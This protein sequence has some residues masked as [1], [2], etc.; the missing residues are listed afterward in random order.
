MILFA[1]SFVGPF[2]AVLA[3]EVDSSNAHATLEVDLA[4]LW[5]ERGG[6]GADPTRVGYRRNALVQLAKHSAHQ[7]GRRI[8]IADVDAQALELEADGI[9]R[10]VRCAD[11]PCSSPTTSFLNGRSQ[12]QPGSSG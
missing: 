1:R 7:L 9:V 11:I 4:A 10:S 5:W 6:Y 12:V 3:K 2:A 8:P